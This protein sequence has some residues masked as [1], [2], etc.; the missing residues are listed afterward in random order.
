MNPPGVALL[1]LAVGGGLIYGFGFA[2]AVFRRARFD[3]RKTKEAVPVLRKD[4]WRTLG[5][6]VK[7]A[8][9]VAVGALVL[10][11]WA[12]AEGKK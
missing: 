7:A 3:H 10:I 9:W 11:A 6:A 1:I 5:I 12:I 4:M 2:V 8:F